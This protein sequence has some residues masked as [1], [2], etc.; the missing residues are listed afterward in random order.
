MGR[1]KFIILS[2]LFVLAIFPLVLS[3]H[4]IKTVDEVGAVMHIDPAD[5]P[6]VG[7]EAVISFDLTK[8]DGDFDYKECVCNL[9]VQPIGAT[10][11][12]ELVEDKLVYRYV[13]TEPKVYTLILS[14]QPLS[15]TTFQPFHFTYEITV[16]SK[17]SSFEQAMQM[18]LHIHGLH[19]FIFGGGFIAV[20][21][22]Y[23]KSKNEPTSKNL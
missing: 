9:H 22:L 16:V 23:L 11:A 1:F 18:F 7:E 2:C 21:V 5:Q 4:E 10:I 13:F 19:A 3:A 14:G 17:R 20:F 6:V 12:H 15:S 8:V